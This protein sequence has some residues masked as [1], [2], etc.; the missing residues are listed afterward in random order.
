MELCDEDSECDEL[1]Y[2]LKTENVKK[3]YSF[4]CQMIRNL[5][6]KELY[7]SACFPGSLKRPTECGF[8]L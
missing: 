2:V 4:G 1:S 3:N 5:T 6:K 7:P 8:M